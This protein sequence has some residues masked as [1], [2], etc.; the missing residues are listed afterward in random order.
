M[1]WQPIDTAPKD[2][3]RVLGYEPS[4]TV[5]NGWIEIIRRVDDSWSGSKWVNSS[6]FCQPQYWM[7]L[8]KPPG[9]E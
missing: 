9:Q 3:T 7:P 8:P 4:A 2:G 5:G 6:G 1:S